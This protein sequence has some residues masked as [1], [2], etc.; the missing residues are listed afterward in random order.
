MRK[1]AA[2]DY[3]RLEVPADGKE[4]RGYGFIN[5][6]TTMRRDQLQ[7][8]VTTLEY[9][10]GKGEWKSLDGATLPAGPVTFYAPPPR[11]SATCTW[12]WRP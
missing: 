4:Y 12:T 5:A 8:T 9:R 7:P 2:I 11:R 1:Q 3:T 6:L 10:V